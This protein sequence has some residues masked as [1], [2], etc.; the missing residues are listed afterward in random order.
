MRQISLEDCSEEMSE[1]YWSDLKDRRVHTVMVIEND[2]GQHLAV[3]F[4]VT[5]HH[6]K[7]PRTFTGRQ[8][9]AIRWFM[10]RIV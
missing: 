10:R 1:E 9:R 6:G 5:D 8:F 7:R 3:T 2:K 4:P